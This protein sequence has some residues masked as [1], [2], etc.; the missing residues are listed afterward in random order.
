MK[1]RHAEQ[2]CLYTLPELSSSPN[3]NYPHPSDPLAPTMSE[4][5]AEERARH[6]PYAALREPNYRFFAGG[7]L[8]ASVGLQMQGTALAWEIYELTHDPF[9]LGIAGL[10]R[11]L[12]VCVLALPAGQI[13][14][15]VNRKH[16]LVATQI[17]FA[18]ASVLLTLASFHHAG[19]WAILGLV[20]V[21]G[22]ARVFNGPS[23]SSLLPQIVPS[24]RFHNAV[25]WNSGLFHFSAMVGPLIAGGI[26]WLT[27]SAWPVYAAAGAGCLFFGL[28]ATRIR[29]PESARR[30][31]P[32]RDIFRYIRPSILVPGML[33]GVAYVRRE[34]TVLGALMLDLFA[35]LLG[36]ATALLP[37]YAKDILHVD[38]VGLGALKA[39]PYVGALL[40]AVYLAHR[41]PFR[42]AGRALLMSV[43]A[44]GLCIIVFG[45]SRSFILSVIILAL[46]GAVDNISVVVRHVLVQARTPDAL[47]GRVSAVNSVF[48][49]CSNELGAF[50]SG[51]VARLSELWLGRVGGAT[52]SVVLGGFG[53]I[54]VVGW[55]A[56][57]W[58]ELR[59]LGRLEV[60]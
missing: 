47:R 11:V 20:S 3:K 50:E 30:S 46:S 15:L 43:A 44:F 31:A 36:G 45:L 38:A 34:K 23:R 53:T 32:L 9:M 59:R 48:I 57:K 14:D 27:G 55:I 40:M 8:F 51:G 24:H 56:R 10:A 2:A 28:C 12:P 7:W 29:L 49:E 60:H 39:A 54:L 58:P 21:T 35:V 16:V 22:C 25:T 4:L 6:D 41:P 5:I 18:L 33:E 26:I 37:V 52:L 13:V 19:V 42:K 1:D 17:A